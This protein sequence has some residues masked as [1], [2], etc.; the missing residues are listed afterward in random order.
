MSKRKAGRP[1]NSG[2]D[3][4][5]RLDAVEALLRQDANLTARAAI[6]RVTGDEDSILRRLQRKLDRRR[7]VRGGDASLLGTLSFE[8]GPV[9]K[10]N[11]WGALV[12]VPLADGSTGWGVSQSVVVGMPFLLVVRGEA[13][14]EGKHVPDH[15]LLKAVD[16]LPRGHGWDH[17]DYRA[18]CAALGFDP[19][20]GRVRGIDRELAE[21]SELFVKG[22]KEGIDLNSPAL[23]S[24]A[25]VMAFQETPK[26]LDAVRLS[27]EHYRLVRVGADP[28]SVARVREAF[29][30]LDW[31]Q[32]S[33]HAVVR[34]LAGPWDYDHDAS[35][36]VHG[37][38][39]DLGASY[40]D[41]PYFIVEPEPGDL[42][43]R[44]ACLIVERHGMGVVMSR[45]EYASFVAG[46]DRGHWLALRDLRSS[47][48]DRRRAAHGA[49]D[50][51]MTSALVEQA[52][53]N[54]YDAY[55]SRR[56]GI[57][58]DPAGT[59][60]CERRKPLVASGTRAPGSRIS[61]ARWNWTVSGPGGEARRMGCVLVQV[62]A[63]TVLVRNGTRAGC[64]DDGPAWVSMT[65][66]RGP[67][68]AWVPMPGQPD[69]RME[70]AKTGE[71]LE[72]ERAMR[73]M[74]SFAWEASRLPRWSEASGRYAA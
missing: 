2:A 61:P 63:D 31:S 16:R 48:W 67:G 66:L 37:D 53:R 25:H 57:P 58:F 73:T 40:L 52:V 26:G 3:D 32:R 28:E 56:A 43:G 29:L 13:P 34:T 10:G 33:T 4:E 21:V 36:Y 22:M 54:G 1:Y 65:L 68:G 64:D 20:S 39:A 35:F 9:R 41:R 30:G 74:R 55:L 11:L 17:A 69:F 24:L 50:L 5:A 72:I 44:L 23:D 6:V 71:P 19:D 47:P 51:G 12:D 46:G 38:F 8:H 7:R 70:D 42:P 60:S 62:D 15:P 45:D 27:D 59:L 14:C 18:C 49:T